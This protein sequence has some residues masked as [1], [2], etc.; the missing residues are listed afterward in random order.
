[1]RREVNDW[2]RHS[3]EFD[4]VVDFDQLLRDPE[5]PFRLRSDFDSGDHL[6]PSDAGYAE[7]AR[8][9]ALITK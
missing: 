7:M 1:V 4:A 9:A 5:H 8:A 2:I 3:G 6:H